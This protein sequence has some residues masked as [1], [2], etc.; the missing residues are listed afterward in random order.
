MTVTKTGNHLAHSTLNTILIVRHYCFSIP[1]HYLCCSCNLYLCF[2]WLSWCCCCCCCSYIFCLT[3]DKDKGKCCDSR[4]APKLKLKAKRKRRESKSDLRFH[5]A[6]SASGAIYQLDSKHQ[7]ENA[8][9]LQDQKFLDCK[10]SLFLLI[11][12]Y[13][14][15]FYL[16]TYTDS[17]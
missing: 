8:N 10:Y 7:V 3:S 9:N 13:M 15:F 11:T 17:C 5:Q 16:Y 12:Y 6:A 1:I 4:N 14:Q 2:R